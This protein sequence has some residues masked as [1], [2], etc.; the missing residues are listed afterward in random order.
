[1]TL[2]VERRERIVELVR[3]QGFATIDALAQRFG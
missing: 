2:E 1:V 3:R